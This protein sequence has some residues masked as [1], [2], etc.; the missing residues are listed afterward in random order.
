[1]KVCYYAMIFG[2]LKVGK[3]GNYSVPLQLVTQNIDEDV[4]AFPLYFTL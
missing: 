3:A 2:M 4:I 1:M